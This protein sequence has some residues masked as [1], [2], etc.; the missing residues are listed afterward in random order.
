MRK[1]LSILALLSLVIFAPSCHKFGEIHTGPY[2]FPDVT[3]GDKYFDF[4]TTAT[5]TLKVQYDLTADYDGVDAAKGKIAVNFVVY[6][7]DPFETQTTSIG[8]QTLSRRALKATLPDTLFVAITD[9]NGGFEGKINV[10]TYVSAKKKKL[11]VYSPYIGVPT[12]LEIPI[13]D[14]KATMDL[15]TRTTRAIETR[16]T[17]VPAGFKL[18]CSDYDAKGKPNNLLPRANLPAFLMD[19]I[20]Y[21]L[22]NEVAIDFTH[23]NYLNAPHITNVRLT[24]KS[25]VNLVFVHQ[26]GTFKNA[27]GYY[28]YL[29]ADSATLKMAD[30]VPI[31][32][33]PNAS[34]APND[35]GL[36][37]GDQVNLKYWDKAANGGQ[38]ALVDSFPAGTSI[39]FFIIADAYRNNAVTNG[40]YTFYSDIKFNPGTY[41]QNVALWDRERKVVVISFEDIG[42]ASGNYWMDNDFNDAVFYVTTEAGNIDD[43]GMD[44]ID[45][46]PDPGP[47]PEGNVLEYKGSIMF[48]DLWPWQGDYDIND[49]M[50]TYHCRIYR[51]KYNFVTKVVD[52]FTPV[53]NGGAMQNAFGYQYLVNST[54]VNS[55]NI[56][57]SGGY[58]PTWKY[59]Q[60]NTWGMELSQTKATVLLFESSHEISSG[61]D[62]T[63]IPKG[64]SWET[65]NV[66]SGK[67]TF[68]VTTTFKNQWLYVDNIGF[69]P[70]NPFIVA[71]V[72]S[73]SGPRGRKEVHLPNFKPSSLVNPN[74]L[75]TGNDKS[76]GPEGYFYVSDYDY[77]F[78]LHLPVQIAPPKEGRRIDQSFTRYNSWAISR[79]TLNTDWYLDP[80]QP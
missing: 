37:S 76:M 23:P 66:N 40:Y 57:V 33:F 69:P 52:K 53:W 49:V 22:P 65:W 58:T 73:V 7:E 60:K 43:D 47:D 15:S 44:E 71:E 10:P 16:A 1:L 45:D 28:S 32:A 41:Q 62:V 19:D 21:T 14:G 38:G 2:D 42:R 72:N 80:Q 3:P 68:T 9:E 70:Y 54:D 6:G 34:Y 8:G 25:S 12:L 11:Y 17:S 36:A 79:G 67:Y 46:N 18:L 51:N 48:E 30:I 59:L 78:A 5:L 26:G 24:K 31:I 77:P 55:V 29:T 74:L 13:A 20:M 64:V 61:Q 63:V 50:L 35:G 75:G 27:I 56:E 39:G 4:S